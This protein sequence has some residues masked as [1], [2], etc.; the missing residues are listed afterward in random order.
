M[1]RNTLLH[2]LFAAA[3]CLIVASGGAAGLQIT[4]DGKPKAVIVLA[5]SLGAQELAVTALVSHVKQ[6]SG[7]T[8]PVMRAKELEGARV[9]AGRLIAPEG[10]TTAQ[11]FIL[12]GD[13]E[14]TQRLGVSLD[15][16][17]PDGI[18]LK[19]TGNVTHLQNSTQSMPPLMNGSINTN[20]RQ[21]L[22]Q[23][24]Q[25][26]TRLTRSLRSVGFSTLTTVPRQRRRSEDTTHSKHHEHT[27]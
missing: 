2:A 1:K 23:L 19:T 26:T 25:T 21:R 8:L 5:G 3:F 22:M 4:E 16:I 15:G 14:L 18:V 7:V 24:F 11:T 13:G 17:S 6:M 9:E 10:K 20:E 27:I 12:L